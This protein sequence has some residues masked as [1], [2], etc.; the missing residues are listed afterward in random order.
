[1]RD[2]ICIEAMGVLTVT[3]TI[4][5]LRA[6]LL[7]H[8]S[9]IYTHRLGPYS[10]PPSINMARVRD[11]DP[12]LRVSSSFC[13]RLVNLLQLGAGNSALLRLSA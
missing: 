4:P 5:I 13:R 7:V 9:Q 11:R 3:T 6:T 1:M 8:G 2:V 10:Q 12:S